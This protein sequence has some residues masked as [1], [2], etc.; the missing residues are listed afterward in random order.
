MYTWLNVL[1]FCSTESLVV[2]NG[3]V[4]VDRP[5][6]VHHQMK[7]VFRFIFILKGCIFNCGYSYELESNMS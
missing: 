3:N 2:A 6:F 7:N 1:H 5:Q 4:S